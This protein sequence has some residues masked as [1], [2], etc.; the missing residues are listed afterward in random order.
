MGGGVSEDLAMTEQ[1]VIV[2]V[3]W[4]KRDSRYITFWRPDNAGYAYPVPWMGLYSR[5]QVESNLAYYNNGT[6]TIAVPAATLE[7]MTEDPRPGEIDNDA[8]PVVLNTKA[9]WERLEAAVICQPIGPIHAR[10]NR[11]LSRDIDVIK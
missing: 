1:F 10:P 3:K 9:N 11:K 5:E 2:S 7:G 8:G 6:F 4:T